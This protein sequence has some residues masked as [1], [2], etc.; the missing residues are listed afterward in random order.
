MKGQMDNSSQA[1]QINSNASLVVCY[2]PV[3]WEKDIAS[4]S[5]LMCANDQGTQYNWITAVE[6]KKDQLIKF[7]STPQNQTL[8]SILSSYPVSNNK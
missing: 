7:H 8:S 6:K 2:G 4:L 5:P 1:K 3:I